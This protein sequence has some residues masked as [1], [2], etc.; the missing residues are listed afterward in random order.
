LN[1][2]LLKAVDKN[3]DEALMRVTVAQEEV[4]MAQEE[5]AILNE[6]SPEVQGLLKQP[7]DHET[8]VKQAKQLQQTRAASVQSWADKAT[9]LQARKT[10]QRILQGQAESVSG[11]LDH[12]E[13]FPYE[14]WTAEEKTEALAVVQDYTQGEIRKLDKAKADIEWSQ[15][16]LLAGGLDALRLPQD[17]PALEK[18]WGKHVMVSVATG[19]E[20][21]AIFKE[22]FKSLMARAKTAESLPAAMVETAQNDAKEFVLKRPFGLGSERVYSTPMVSTNHLDIWKKKDDTVKKRVVVYIQGHHH[23]DAQKEWMDSDEVKMKAQLSE[24]FKTGDTP[25]VWV[26]FKGK[27]K[28]EVLQALTDLKSQA[29][30][31]TEFLV[32]MNGHGMQ[33][34]SENETLDPR[35]EGSPVGHFQLTATEDLTDNEMKDALQH[36]SGSGGVLLWLSSCHGAAWLAQHDTSRKL[37]KTRLQSSPFQSSPDQGLTALA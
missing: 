4:R 7:L 23:V 11:R 14:H 2:Q 9:E 30:P 10:S 17:H 6:L 12:P 34:P 33:V 1:Q 35:L 3:P 21:S 25:L 18:Q 19:Q 28:Q 16:Q 15:Q 24:D 36:L 27:T 13:Y 8:I 20:Q 32:V 5:A 29:T 31:D 37:N 26:P 22:H